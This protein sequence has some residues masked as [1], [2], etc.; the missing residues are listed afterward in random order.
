MMT[1]EKMC[2]AGLSLV[3]DDFISQFE[4]VAEIDGTNRIHL[5]AN[6]CQF[7]WMLNYCMLIICDCGQIKEGTAIDEDISPEKAELMV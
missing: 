2:I 5:H 6:F 7:L 1:H 4:G 3:K